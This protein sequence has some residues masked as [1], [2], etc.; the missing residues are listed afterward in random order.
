MKPHGLN[1]LQYARFQLG[2][3]SA[4]YGKLTPSQR[5]QRARLMQ[6]LGKPAELVI[7]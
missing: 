2:A 1:A 6:Q 4:N 3:L 7:A 5:E